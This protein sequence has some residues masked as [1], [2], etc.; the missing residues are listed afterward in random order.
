MNRILFFLL[1]GLLGFLLRF[2]SS[3]THTYLPTRSYTL[4]IILDAVIVFGI[5]ILIAAAYLKANSY[6]GRLKNCLI[7]GAFITLAFIL[8]DL[9]Y[10]YELIAE[11]PKIILGRIIACSIPTATFSILYPI[12]IKKSLTDRNKYSKVLDSQDE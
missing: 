6:V 5:P 1:L 9:N 12:F 8:E 10:M 2:V 7:A 11:D 3:L 4:Y